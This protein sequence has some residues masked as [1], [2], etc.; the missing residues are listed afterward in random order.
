MHIIHGFIIL[1]IPFW[2]IFLKIKRKE[3]KYYGLT[4]E[5]YKDWS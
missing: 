5:V 1:S 2:G 4:D 3:L